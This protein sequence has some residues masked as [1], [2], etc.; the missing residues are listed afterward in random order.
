LLVSKNEKIHFQRALD[1]ISSVQRDPCGA[2]AKYGQALPSGKFMDGF[3]LTFLS[4][5][6]T[7]PIV[8]I[9]IGESG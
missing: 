2:I 3:D 9:E 4:I 7:A 6:R 8:M 5:S 1:G